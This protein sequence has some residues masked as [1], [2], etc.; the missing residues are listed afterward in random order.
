MLYQQGCFERLGLS[1]YRADDVQRIHDIC[2]EKGYV[3]PTVYQGNYNPLARRA[4]TELFPVLRKLGIHFNAYSATAGGF[5]TKTAQQVNDSDNAGRFNK[6]SPVAF[7]YRDAY[8]KPAMLSQLAVW[9]EIARDAGCS[10]ADLA[11]RWVKYH[12]GLKRDMGDGI[13]IGARTADQLQGT[14]RG[15]EEGML[16]E[17]I[18]KR[19]DAV[20][21]VVKEEAPVVEF[22][23]Q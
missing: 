23:R 9:S 3:K 5:L 15:L 11:N 18:C 17:S 14:L 20:W 16:S 8:A 2:T 7:A 13:I 12:S 19:I 6:D 1:N 22:L 10:P 4:E 21:G